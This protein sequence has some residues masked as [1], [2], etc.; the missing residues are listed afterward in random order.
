M[1]AAV[2]R[3]RQDY[4]RNS[5]SQKIP[6]PGI[7]EEFFTQVS[8]EIEGRV[9]KK[10]SQEFRRTESCILEALSNLEEF[11]L[12]PQIRT[13][14]GTVPGALRNSVIENQEPSGDRSQNDPHPEM[15]FSAG[16]ISNFIASDPKE[17]SHSFAF[18]KSRS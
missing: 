6:F 14:T 5:P 4:S 16:C 11:F 17:T 15:K 3:E 7:A 8:E 18:Q 10:L 2:S 9:L 12:K 13:L 1:L